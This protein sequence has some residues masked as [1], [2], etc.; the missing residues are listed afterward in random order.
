[1]RYIKNILNPYLGISLYH[2]NEKYLLK[3]EKSNIEISFKIPEEDCSNLDELEKKILQPAF[4]ES[5]RAKFYE[6]Q[7]MLNLI[8]DEE[9]SN[10]EG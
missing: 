9:G 3:F 6:L 4:L 8:L 2:L 7:P 10:L 5:L 1:M